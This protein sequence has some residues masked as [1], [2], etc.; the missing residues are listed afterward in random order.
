MGVSIPRG[1][2]AH[3]D[4]SGDDSSLPRAPEPAHWAPPCARCGRPM[5]PDVVLFQ[6]ELPQDQLAAYQ[7]ELRRGF[8]VVFAIGTSAAFPYIAGP[9]IQAA[10]EG[11]PTV[12]INPGETELSHFV[13]YRFAAP[14][15][16]V[17]AALWTSDFSRAETPL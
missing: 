4:I 7:R 5:R 15:G 9:V 11:V 1:G 16:T 12:E 8:D 10:R 13:S 3:G 6:E 2:H 17:L 14:A